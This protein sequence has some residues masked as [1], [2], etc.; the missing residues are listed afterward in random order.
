MPYSG[1]NDF[2]GTLNLQ[3]PFAQDSKRLSSS[4]I[5]NKLTAE[6]KLIPPNFSSVY[7]L[8]TVNGYTSFVMKKYN[9]L[10]QA[11]DKINSLYEQIV[12]FNP[13][14]SQRGSDLAL[15]KIDL[16]RIDLSDPIFNQLGVKYWVTDRDLGLPETQLV[17]RDGDVSVYRNNQV[18]SRAVLLDDQDKII[19]E[20]LLSQPNS[21][22]LILEIKNRGKLVIH[23]TFYPG[24]QARVNGQP[25]TIDPYGDIFRSVAVIQ[26]NSRVIFDFRPRSF[27]IGLWISLASFLLVSF[28]L[29][30]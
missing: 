26:D 8:A 9:R 4:E 21:N 5:S 3:T 15:S 18:L 17:Y 6:M 25:V 11:N 20:P 13:L 12:K 24:W 29:L 7:N 14:I 19:E 30:I 27:Y 10:F 16:A 22:Q 2:F 28:W 23:D 1:L